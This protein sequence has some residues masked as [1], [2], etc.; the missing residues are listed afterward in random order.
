[1]LGVVVRYAVWASN[2]RGLPPDVESIFTP[3]NIA[4]YVGTAVKDEYTVATRQRLHRQ[5]ETVGRAVTRRAPFE[6][7]PRRERA[8]RLRAPYTN[9][10][11]ALLSADA[12][13]QATEFRTRAFRGLLWVGMG[14]GL[15]GDDQTRITGSS[16]YRSDGL[17]WVDVPA[18]DQVPARTIAVHRE[19]ADR[20]ADL[21]ATYPEEPLAGTPRTG[22]TRVGSAFVATLTRSFTYGLRTP[23]LV[24]GRIRTTWGVHQIVAGTPISVVARAMGY[25]HMKSLGDL[26]DQLPPASDDER[27]LLAG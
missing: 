4:F 8:H 11:V 15:S 26:L 23:P 20:V 16:F 5:L 17:L 10:E 12:E 21:A 2:D 7:P 27:Y 13:N 1:M 25:K 3:D 14:T 6:A 24:P 18:R 22:R 9:E 19:W